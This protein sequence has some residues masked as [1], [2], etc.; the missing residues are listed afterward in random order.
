M[1]PLIVF[2]SVHAVIENG[3]AGFERVA[4]REAWIVR[5]RPDGS[6]VADDV[7]NDERMPN[8]GSG[9]ICVVVVVPSAAT[10]V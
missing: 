8:R 10:D 9:A 3:S 6:I 2:V 1:R 4:V 7:A 5:V